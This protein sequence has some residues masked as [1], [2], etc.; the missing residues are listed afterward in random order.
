LGT[1]P[2]V[3]AG[4]DRFAGAAFLPVDVVS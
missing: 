2:R 3:A 4:I 1:T